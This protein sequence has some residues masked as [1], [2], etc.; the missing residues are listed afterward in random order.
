MANGE[1]LIRRREDDFGRDDVTRQSHRVD[2]CAADRGAA[3]LPWPMDILDW[4]ASL[5]LTD[6]GEPL[7]HLT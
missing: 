2:L 5:G 6:F 3:R 4:Y 7:R 1:P